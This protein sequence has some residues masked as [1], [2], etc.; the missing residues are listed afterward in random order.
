MIEAA[1]MILLGVVVGA[2][3]NRVRGGLFVMP[4][5][6]H[7][8][9]LIG[10]AI[11]MGLLAGLISGSPWLGAAAA[12]GAFLGCTM[13]EYDSQS[14]GL[15]GGRGG[16]EAWIFMTAWG[17]AR[18]LPP[19]IAIAVWHLS[20]G[21]FKAIAMTQAI[22]PLSGLACA[23]IYYAVRWLPDWMLFAKGFGAGTGP[24]A[25]RD[26]AEWAELLHGA[27][28]GAALVA[29]VGAM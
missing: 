29:A 15:K 25:A 27:A 4:G 17:L 23:P 3:G 8:A 24:G 9:R 13:G 22:M 20:G 6:D 26:P 2:L 16:E 10:W 14:M 5:G 12:G 19:M 18:V 21:N 11:P 28:M 1:A 7:V